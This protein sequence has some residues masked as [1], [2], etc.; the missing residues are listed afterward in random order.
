MLKQN[1]IQSVANGMNESFSEYFFICF[2]FTVSFVVATDQ[3][4]ITITDSSI[5]EYLANRTQYLNTNRNQTTWPNII[6]WMQGIIAGTFTLLLK[7]SVEMLGAKYVKPTLQKLS[8][9]ILTKLKKKMRKI[10]TI[11]ITAFMVLT[12]IAYIASAQDSTAFLHNGE[13][14]HPWLK[15]AVVIAGCLYEI[16]ARTKTTTKDYS[17]IN[18]VAHIV[19]N[20]FPN[21][22]KNESQHGFL[23]KRKKV[24]DDSNENWN[25]EK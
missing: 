3:H 20:I 4:T 12:G 25:I 7:P 18:F 15:V 1:F 16:I 5:I 23:F 6:N 9:K 11:T 19:D 13:F 10:F 8:R 21:H 2:A 14:K 17:V 22:A 24:I